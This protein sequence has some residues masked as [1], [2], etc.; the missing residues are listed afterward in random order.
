MTFE[1]DFVSYT[2]VSYYV[3][4]PGDLSEPEEA[5]ESVQE[6]SNLV[7]LHAFPTTFVIVFVLLGK[8]V[9]KQMP[10]PFCTRAVLLKLV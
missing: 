8:L 5:S 4:E 2:T 1:I 3:S 10:A 7:A 9:I 6:P